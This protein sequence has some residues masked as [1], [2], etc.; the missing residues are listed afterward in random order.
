MSQV[1][2]NYNKNQSIMSSL[3]IEK[4]I[5]SSIFYDSNLL[6]DIKYIISSNNFINSE[7]KKI[8]STMLELHS[9]DIPIDEIMV[10]SKS[11]NTINADIIPE[12]LAT[13]PLT[14]I[15]EYAKELKKAN[16]SQQIYLL[17][18]KLQEKFDIE[19]IE[20]MNALKL[21]IEEIDG[22]RKLKLEDDRLFNFFEKL[23]LDF[24]E[25][26]KIKFEYLYDDL[27]VKNEITMLS[28]LPGVGK[29]LISVHLCDHLLKTKKIKQLF[30]LDGDN[31]LSTIKDRNIH[32][33]KL[34]YGNQFRYFVGK[35]RSE[36]KQIIQKLQQMNLEDTLI[37]FDSIKNFIDGDRDKNKD[38]SIVMETLK[39]LRNN[40]ATVLFL[41]HQNKKQKDFN[42]DFAGSSAFAEDT[43]NAIRLEF[44]KDKETFIL[45]P[46]KARAGHLEEIALKLDN[47]NLVRV[48]VEFAKQTAEDEEMI[49]ETI[50]FIKSSYSQPI[51]SDL[52]KN[53]IELGYNKEKASKIIKAGEGKIWNFK[54]GDRNNQKVY[55]L[56]DEKETIIEYVYQD[57]TRTTKSTKRSGRSERTPFDGT[58]K[59]LYNNTPYNT[60]QKSTQSSGISERSGRTP[61]DGGFDDLYSS[62]NDKNMSLP[63]IL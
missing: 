61:F 41:H 4:S 25:V 11:K 17:T 15:A 26:D 34:K 52:W 6:D 48:D 9:A 50:E 31:G 20:Q 57:S 60:K 36:L 30:Y 23:D 53:L 14:N 37:V 62:M 18:I 38:V 16:L 58:S 1:H 43:T 24:D 7:Y 40:G 33:Y 56:I 51:W 47:S 3:N 44:N 29:S 32:H 5:L 63:D 54:R 8:Y 12:I 21:Q 39:S 55:F 2:S 59:E 35:S 13:T 22:I 28:S 19:L 10:L 49:I 27:L 42:S 46:F 45:T